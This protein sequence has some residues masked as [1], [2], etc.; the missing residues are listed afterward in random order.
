MI[1]ITM[2]VMKYEEMNFLWA[3]CQDFYVPI[4]LLVLVPGI[5]DIPL[6]Q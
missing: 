2:P 4:S 3:K 5:K 6:A 1:S